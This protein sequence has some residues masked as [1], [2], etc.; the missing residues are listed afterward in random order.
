MANPKETKKMLDW[1]RRG[2]RLW[3]IVACAAAGLILLVA[4]IVLDDRQTAKTGG[5]TEGDWQTYTAA[6]EAKAADLCTRVAGVSDVTVAVSLAQG[7]EYV[8]AGEDGSARK[9]CLSLSVHPRSAELGWVWRRQPTTRPLYRHCS[10]F[11]PQP[12]A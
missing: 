2:G 1:M 6:L 10:L 8:Y 4:G 5:S 11:S 9:R 3:L 12:S 7:V